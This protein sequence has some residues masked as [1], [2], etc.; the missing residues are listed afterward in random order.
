MG[1]RHFFGIGR[2]PQRAVAAVGTAVGQVR[3][4]FA[5]ALQRILTQ[6]QFGG[7]VVEYQQV[8]HAG[9]RGAVQAGVQHQH[10][11]AATGQ[12]LGTGGAD[13]AG[14]DHDH[15][16]HLAL[17]HGRMPQANG[18]SCSMIRLASAL[19]NARPRMVGTMRSPCSS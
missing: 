14:A 11:Q 5:P 2:Q 16:G 4:Q 17:V 19:M 8:A 9:G 7:V 10:L 18:S 13:N 3:A 1:H 6:G 12:R 15:I